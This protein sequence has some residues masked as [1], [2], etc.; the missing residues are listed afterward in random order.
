MTKASKRAIQVEKLISYRLDSLLNELAQMFD[1]PLFT[2]E[3]TEIL[4]HFLFDTP[5]GGKGSS[6]RTLNDYIDILDRADEA[7]GLTP[8]VE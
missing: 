2:S 1:C 6:S 8:Y 4:S 7:H 3:A 5:L